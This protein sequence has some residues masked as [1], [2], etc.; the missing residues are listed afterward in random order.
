MSKI[1]DMKVEWAD[2]VFRRDELANAK[3][4]IGE[5]LPELA[6][7]GVTKV[8]VLDYN[9]VNEFNVDTNCGPFKLTFVVGTNECIPIIT[10]FNQ[11]V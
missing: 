9:N 10:Q 6:A 7:V 2:E 1:R 5:W 4:M 8:K 11:I 3:L